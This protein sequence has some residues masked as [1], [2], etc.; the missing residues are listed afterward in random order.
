MTDTRI[1]FLLPPNITF[2]DFVSPP[3]NISTILKNGG[4]E[5]FGSVITDIPLGVLS[6]SAYLKKFHSVESRVIDFN[7]RLNQEASFTFQNFAS[8]FKSEIG[9]YADFDPHYICISAL[10]TPAYNSILEL[11]QVSKEIFPNALVLAG[12]NLP[13][14]MYKEILTDTK[15][16]DAICFGEGE[17]PLNELLQAE[18]KQGFLNGHS[19]WITHT[20]IANKQTLF[21]HDFI[22]DLD[23]I[24]FL[25]YGILDLEGYKL[26]STLSRYSVSDKLS[27]SI[28]TSGEE[29]T[30]FPIMTSRGCPFRC[31]FCA[32]HA[33]HGRKM[34]YY[35]LER[36]TEDLKQ[37]K[38]LFDVSGI[39]IQDDHFMGGDQRPYDIVSQI[40]TFDLKM[41]FQNALAIY[42]L[43][44]DFLKL[45]K[46]AGVRE[47]VL[48]IES[49]SARVLKE[50]MRKPLKLKI[51]QDVTKNCRE[52]GIYTDCNIILGMPGE[53]MQDIADSRE[54]LKTLYADWFRVFVAMPIPGSEMYEECEIN[55][56]FKITPMKANY[57]NAVIETEFLTPQDVQFMTYYMN[58][59]LN[60]VYN[61]NF[62]LGHYNTALESF[63][64]VIKVKPDHAIAHFYIGQ[65]YEKLGKASQAETHY[66]LARGYTQET[67]F[68]DVFINDFEIPIH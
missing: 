46:E 36:V 43:K 54:F 21:Q 16:V 63:L 29:E 51:V 4:K 9:Q 64:N 61:A 53:T 33:A 52:A 23:E 18:D 25:D 24:P 38:D 14:S 67:D 10:F 45:L 55:D 48:P 26:N 47:L 20:N 32:S 42:A 11:A 60:F 56:Y 27:D 2:E 59:E 13:T 34:R 19:S 8:Y 40:K 44:P 7:V 12:G 66:S 22:Y 3:N 65:C 39:I 28:G 50:V 31:T 41:F 35:S 6:L 30:S 49:G 58:I 57:K 1:L 17:K 15:C 62:R 5:Q 37:L 68:W